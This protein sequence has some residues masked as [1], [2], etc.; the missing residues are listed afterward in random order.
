MSFKNR[1]NEWDNDKRINRAK[2]LSN[3]IFDLVE[4]GKNLTVMEYGCATGLL[5]FN[6]KD[7]FKKITLID[8]E[9]E[10]IKIVQK[11]IK[12]NNID[13]IFPLNIDLISENYTEEKFDVIYTSLTLHH[14]LNTKDIIKKFYELLN[15]NGILIIID[16][17]KEDG[18]FH[19]NSPSFKGH[20]GFEH[21]YINNIMNELG[22]KDIKIESFYKDTKIIKEKI[23]PYSL[24]YA[25]GKKLNKN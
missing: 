9:I 22:F 5:S 6:L 14:I 20:N 19:I 10:M 2:I 7:N 16:L 13:N 8:N 25:I 21:S 3:K 1:A 12:D 23:I 18:T 4:N 15:K 17:D 24:F 11:K